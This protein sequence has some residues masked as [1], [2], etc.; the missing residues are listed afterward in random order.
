MYK[1]VSPL[2]WLIIYFSLICKVYN[3]YSYVFM[4]SGNL[5]HNTIKSIPHLQKGVAM[6]VACRKVGG[7]QNLEEIFG[8]LCII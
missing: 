3:T 6:I 4:L 8:N 1:E 5:V 2:K 7:V